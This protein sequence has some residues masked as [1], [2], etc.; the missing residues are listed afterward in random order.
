MIVI[1]QASYS[2]FMRRKTINSG[3]W[4]LVHAWA[5][6]AAFRRLSE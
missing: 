3:E 2:A 1:H 6:G 5:C 4:L